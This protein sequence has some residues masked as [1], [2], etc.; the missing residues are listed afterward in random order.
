VKNKVV[1]IASVR[2]VCRVH[3]P[4]AIASESY[5]T[6]Y[7]LEGIMSARFLHSLSAHAE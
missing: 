1:Q 6:S 5:H 3:T 7:H 4:V 2:G